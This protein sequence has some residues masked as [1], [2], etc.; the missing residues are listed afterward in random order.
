VEPVSEKSD[1]VEADELLPVVLVL[2]LADV[3]LV[4]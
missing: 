4:A 2:V 3:V 1:E